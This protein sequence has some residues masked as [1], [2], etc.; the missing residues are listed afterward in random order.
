MQRQVCLRRGSYSEV[1]FS[2]CEEEEYRANA[3]VMIHRVQQT[4]DSTAMLICNNSDA[5]TSIKFKVVY[6]AK[7]I[8]RFSDDSSQEFV[9]IQ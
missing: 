3:V 7:L 6:T 5:I 4:Q 2:A 9:S 8:L 1:L